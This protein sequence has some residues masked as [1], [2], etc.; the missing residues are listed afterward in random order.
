MNRAARLEIRPVD[1]EDGWRL[2]AR[3][4]SLAEPAHGLNAGMVG[5][6]HRIASEHDTRPLGRRHRLQ[7][8]RHREIV[9]RNLLAP[10][11]GTHRR[12]PQRGPAHANRIENGLLGTDL[13]EGAILTGKRC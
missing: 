2:A 5:V 1:S 13:E 12:L 7:H 10:P 4:Q 6:A 3:N 9:F 8:H 11:I